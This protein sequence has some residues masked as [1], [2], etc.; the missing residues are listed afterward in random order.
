MLDSSDG[1]TA[2]YSDL[3]CILFYPLRTFDNIMQPDL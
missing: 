2:Y 3:I 1:R